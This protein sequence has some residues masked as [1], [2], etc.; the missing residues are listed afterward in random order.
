[1]FA[2]HV[3]SAWLLLASTGY[4]FAQDLVPKS[5]PQANP[6]VL[7]NAVL[8]TMSGSVLV[9]GTLWFLDGVIRGV[10]AEGLKPD[11]PPRS[12]PIV[13][14]LKGKHV[15]P[16][17]IS[18]HTTLGLVEI[19]SV[20]QTVDTDE[21]GEMSPEAVAAVAVNPDSAAIPVA[22][23]NGILAAGV[24]PI[25]GLMPG[26]ASVMQLDGW[27]NKDL[28]VKANAGPI[29]AWPQQIVIDV[30]RWPLLRPDTGAENTKKARKSIDDAFTAAQAWL[31]A[32]MADPKVPLDIR[33][34]ALV[35]A[36]R[37]EVP[38]FLLAED[39]EQIESAVLWA[40]GRKLRPVIVGGRAA[41][42][43]ASLLRDRHVPVIID[44][45]HRLP[46]RDDS[47]YDESFTL[48]K[49]LFDQGVMFCIATGMDFSTDRNL[50]YHAATAA[51]FGLDRDVAMLAVT[52]RAAE[53]L[54]VSDRLG[55][56]SVGKDATL[57]VADGHPFDLPTVIE[58]AFVRGQKV[59]LRNKQTELAQKYRER[60]RQM[61]G[62]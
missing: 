43:C 60:Y 16:G 28:T 50:P 32:H 57:F 21:L 33:H 44:G 1:M 3:R 56:L 30:S 26:R 62:R 59:D 37:G 38:V 46:Q 51:A 54:S 25:G 20:R 58:L 61:S 49:R 40:T 14:D 22:R 27:T 42:Q 19:S 15:F 6:V 55:S 23:S 52:L 11:L 5:S 13:I 41:G 2:T 18:A 35:Q 34:E 29:I 4:L 12:E 9:G 48:P 31:E 10:L 8:H 17:M 36:L 24:F 45:I 7:T 47:A 53:I 39:L